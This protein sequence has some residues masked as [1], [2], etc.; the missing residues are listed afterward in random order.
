MQLPHDG[1]RS[2][3][4]FTTH[5]ARDSRSY[6]SDV[7][8]GTYEPCLYLLPPNASDSILAV[9]LCVCVNNATTGARARRALLCRY[10]VLTARLP[11]VPLARACAL[12]L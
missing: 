6:Y 7:D 5:A 8:L 9:V 3:L 11:S 10:R 1:S 2:S 12:L 4:R